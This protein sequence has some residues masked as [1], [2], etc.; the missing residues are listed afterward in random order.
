MWQARGRRAWEEAQAEA[1]RATGT[2]RALTIDPPPLAGVAPIAPLVAIPPFAVAPRNGCSA[3]P[4]EGE[5]PLLPGNTLIDRPDPRGRA[6]ERGVP[7]P[8]PRPR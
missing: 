4:G 7:R 6:V 2:L 8:R 5:A 3:P 1:D